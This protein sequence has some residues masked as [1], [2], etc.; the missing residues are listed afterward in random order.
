MRIPLLLTLLLVLTTAAS[1]PAGPHAHNDP[2]CRGPVDPAAIEAAP[3]AFFGPL[4]RASSP[5]D[6]EAY[7]ESVDQARYASLLRDLSGDQSFMLD[8]QSRTISTRWTGSAGAATGVDLARD[9]IADRFAAA[10]YDVVLQDFQNFVAGS[11]ITSTN[12]IAVKTGTVAP[13]EIL[14][15]GAHYDAIAETNSAPAP[16]AEDNG[17]GTAAVLHLAELLAGFKTERTIHFVAFGAEEYGLRGSNHYV[18]EAQAAGDQVIAALTM[19]MI[20]AWVDDFG[21]W[22]ESEAFTPDM[23]APVLELVGIV[24]DNVDQWTTIARTTHFDA[25]GSDHVPFLQNGIPAILAIEEDWAAYAPYHRSTDTF[26]KVD[27]AL[28]T[29]I[30]R[31]IA[32]CIADMANIYRDVKVGGPGVTPPRV[33]LLDLA[34]ALPNPFNPRTTLSFSTPTAG[35]TRLEI[36]DLR[37]RRVRSLVSGSLAAGPH[38]RVWD[39]L[40]DAGLAVASGVYS[41]RLTHPEGIR[42]QRLTLVR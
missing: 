2:A 15:V 32:G 20:S 26:D 1:A 41:A 35:L 18:D 42:T 39:G 11:Q 7:V 5:A 36:F 30:T 28:G 17:S 31:A 23:Q 9:Y 8:G 37:G 24:E 21:I 10:G 38:E 4:P 27:P 13:E 19:D 25:F 34:P 16:G 12:V 22:I 3:R 33:S 40:D 29:A 6:E 14:V